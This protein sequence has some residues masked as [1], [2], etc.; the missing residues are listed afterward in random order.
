MVHAN[1]VLFDYITQGDPGCIKHTKHYLSRYPQF[2]QE[3]VELAA[4][5]RALSTIESLLPP[6][7]Q[8]RRVTPRAPRPSGK[9]VNGKGVAAKTV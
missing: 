5:W 2:R 3:I 8:V 1:K 6:E 7:G 9:L 4:M